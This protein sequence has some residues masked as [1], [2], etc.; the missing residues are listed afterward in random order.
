MVL[1]SI[2]SKHKQFYAET[3]DDLHRSYV[4]KW[5]VIVGVA[6]VSV[7]QCSVITDIINYSVTQY[8]ER[9]E[10]SGIKAKRNQLK[11]TVIIHI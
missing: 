11:S 7:V 2:S 1:A 5:S 9:M 6:F 10:T 8:I 4:Y 3:S